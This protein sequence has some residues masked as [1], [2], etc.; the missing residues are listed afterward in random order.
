MLLLKIVY[1]TADCITLQND[2]NQILKYT[3]ENDITLNPLKSQHMRIS[4][5]HTPIEHSYYLNET[6]IETVSQ[7]KHLG[8]IYDNKLTFNKHCD[9]I[10]AKALKNLDF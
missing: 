8:V 1:D 9:S 4:L 10:I 2:L 6:R 5:K 7:H 3:K